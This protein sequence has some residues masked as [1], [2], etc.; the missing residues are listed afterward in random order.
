MSHDILGKSNV[1]EVILDSHYV[2]FSLVIADDGR[3][4]FQ[5]L[6][7]LNYF[8]SYIRH[9]SGGLH[10]KFVFWMVD[11]CCGGSNFLLLIL[12]NTE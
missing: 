9:A 3:Y 12:L 10:A 5:L 4:I 2:R 8:Y 1:V 11:N 7:T 6:L